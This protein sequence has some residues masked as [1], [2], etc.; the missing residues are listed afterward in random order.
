MRE[1]GMNESCRFI[2][3]VLNA[4]ARDCGS[5]GRSG[6]NETNTPIPLHLLARVSRGKG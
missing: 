4:R 6:A 5:V 3:M 1:I 2:W